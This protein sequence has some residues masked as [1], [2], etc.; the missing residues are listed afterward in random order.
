MLHSRTAIA[1][2][3]SHTELRKYIDRADKRFATDHAAEKVKAHKA[4]QKIGRKIAALV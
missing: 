3:S 2:R 4:K 1:Q